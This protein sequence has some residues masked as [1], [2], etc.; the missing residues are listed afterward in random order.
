MKFILI[1]DKKNQTEESYSTGIF[2]IYETKT[3]ETLI[4]T[5][6]QITFSLFLA[7]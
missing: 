4:S 6:N 7:Y 2:K 5:A 1:K 3:I